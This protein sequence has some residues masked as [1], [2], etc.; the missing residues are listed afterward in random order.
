MDLFD[1]LDRDEESGE[2]YSALPAEVKD[3]LDQSCGLIH[4]REELYARA[5]AL[6]QGYDPLN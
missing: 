5:E 2:F 3:A 1:L 6:L 4:S